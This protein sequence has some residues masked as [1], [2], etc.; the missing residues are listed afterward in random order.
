MF[1]MVFYKARIKSITELKVT[2]R[3]HVISLKRYLWSA[4]PLSRLQ[5]KGK[6]GRTKFSKNNYKSFISDPMTNNI[7]IV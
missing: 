4:F 1:N 3:I 5:E 7:F 2:E 6:K